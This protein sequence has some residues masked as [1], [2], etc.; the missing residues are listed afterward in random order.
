MHPTHLPLLVWAQAIYLV[1]HLSP[2]GRAAIDLLP[3]RVEFEIC[4]PTSKVCCSPMTL[5]GM[6]I[7][8]AW[9]APSYAGAEGAK[10]T[11]LLRENARSVTL[12]C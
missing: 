12:D 1:V 6:T 3:E 7:R 4:K 10:P 5:S 8:S 11:H 2:M 9:H